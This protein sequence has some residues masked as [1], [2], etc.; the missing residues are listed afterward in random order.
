MRLSGEAV[1]IEANDFFRA[2]S[3]VIRQMGA[4]AA[5][6]PEF[7]FQPRPGTLT[8]FALELFAQ[9]LDNGVG[10]RLARDFCELPSQFVGM[11]V[12]DVERHGESLFLGF[13][14]LILARLLVPMVAKPTLCY[15]GQ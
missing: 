1:L 12:F 9:S 15:I 5:D 14:F 11:Y 2:A 4:S 13:F 8:S 7:V 6:R 10:D 3:V